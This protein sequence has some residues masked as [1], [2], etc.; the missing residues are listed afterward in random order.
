MSSLKVLYVDDEPDIREIA[1]LA[2]ELD[3]DIEVRSAPS[4]SAALQEAAEWH[5]DAILLDVMM[6]DMDGPATLSRLREREAT[7]EIP[8]IFITAR[9][10]TKEIA[11]LKSLGAIDVIT[12]PFDPMALASE[13][14]RKIRS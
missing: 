10:Q 1:A 9:A 14:R 12:K 13:V 6:P 3:S 4:G 11:Q 8:V 7:K 5:P 2:L